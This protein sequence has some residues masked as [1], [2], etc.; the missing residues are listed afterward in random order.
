M[1]GFPNVAYIDRR[2]RRGLPQNADDPRITPP[3]SIN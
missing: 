2:C 3:M 1:N